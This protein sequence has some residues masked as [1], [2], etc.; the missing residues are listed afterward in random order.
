MP[1]DETPVASGAAGQVAERRPPE[2]VR[3]AHDSRI[4]AYYVPRNGL[5]VSDLRAHLAARLPEYM[6]PAAFVAL[7][8]LP[9]TSN[10]KVDRKALPGADTDRRLSTDAYVAART[11][12]EEV[13]AAIW[14]EVL[15]AERV[16]V[17]DN[18]SEAG[19]HSLLATQLVSRV[20]Q[21]F[22]VDLPLRT[23]FEHPTVAGLATRLD[24][25][26]DGS[27]RDEPIPSAPRDRPLPLSFAQRR[28]WFLDQLQPSGSAL[29]A[30]SSWGATPFW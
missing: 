19:G 24:A 4:V 12:T 13:L 9:L 16:G 20:R 14:A 30:S 25:Q 11:P 10:G 18:F 22:G 2:C 6:V 8:S 1:S 27:S 29:T 23:V 5:T 7:E 17:H 28:L 15:G 21:S 3:V 26:R